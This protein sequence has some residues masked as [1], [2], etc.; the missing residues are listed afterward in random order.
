MAEHEAVYWQWRGLFK[1][2]TGRDSWRKLRWTM[3]E[4]DAAAWAA[5]NRT[6]VEKV[7]NS[8]QSRRV[9]DQPTFGLMPSMGKK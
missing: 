7:P 1:T 8:A 5:N 9:T 4:E 6:K 2:R 3:T